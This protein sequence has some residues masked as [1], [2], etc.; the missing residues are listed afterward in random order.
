MMAK[1]SGKWKKAANAVGRKICVALYYMWLTAQDFSYE[2]Y[3]IVK[4]T[5]IFDIPVDNLPPLNPFLNGIFAF[6]MTMMSIL[7][8]I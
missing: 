3:S 7:L 5:V 4:N 2:N 1:S 6:F 8:L